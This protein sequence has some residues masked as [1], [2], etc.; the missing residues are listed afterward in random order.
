MSRLVPDVIDFSDANECRVDGI[1][2]VYRVSQNTI[3]VE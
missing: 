2:G 3:C 1:S